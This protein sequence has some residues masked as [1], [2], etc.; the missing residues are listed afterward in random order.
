MP[1]LVVLF[2]RFGKLGF[3]IGTYIIKIIRATKSR[4]PFIFNFRRK[5]TS[6]FGKNFVYTPPIRPKVKVLRIIKDSSP[7]FCIK[8]ARI[9]PY[10]YQF[11][12]FSS[13]GFFYVVVC[14]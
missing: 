4:Y 9:D 3:E 1:F 13:L 8:C 7:G 11:V 14:A 6:D 2:F 10:V 12:V 5:W